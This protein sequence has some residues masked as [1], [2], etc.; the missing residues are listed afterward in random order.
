[1][2]TQGH[3]RAYIRK[4]YTVTVGYVSETWPMRTETRQ[5]YNIELRDW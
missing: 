3:F 5:A 4:V 1:V 2:K